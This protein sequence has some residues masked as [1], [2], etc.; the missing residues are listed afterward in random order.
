[1]FAAVIEG[2]CESQ[3]AVATDQH[4]A[5]QMTEIEQEESFF[6]V[7]VRDMPLRRR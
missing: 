2:A 5:L 3:F 4:G 7:N 6:L 1:M